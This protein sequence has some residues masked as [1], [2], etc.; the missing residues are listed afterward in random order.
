MEKLSKINMSNLPSFVKEVFGIL[1]DT[2]TYLVGG[3][4]R[5]II[6]GKEPKDFDFA[7]NLYPESVVL[8]FESQ[9][10]DTIPTGIDYGTV[11]VMIDKEPIEITTFRKDVKYLDGRRPSVISFSETI[12]ED[13]SRR[14]F[15]I[16]AMAVNSTGEITDPYDGMIDLQKGIVKTVG[17]A[18]DRF[19][20]DKLRMLR[21][22][23]FAS[24]FNFKLDY[25]I[26]S[27]VHMIYDISNLSKERITSE[28]GKIITSETPSKYFMQMEFIYMISSVIPELKELYKLRQ[29]N[30]NHCYTNVYEHSVKAMDKVEPQ[31]H[32]RLAMLFHDLGKLET[33]T[34]DENGIDHF[35]QHDKNSETMTKLIMTRLKY[36]NDMINKVTTLIGNHMLRYDE[37]KP[38]TAR[39]FLNRMGDNWEDMIKI[40]VADRLGAVTRF[41]GLEKIFR[42]KFECERAIKNEDCVSTNQLAI[43]GNDL[44]KMGLPQGK[45][46]GII[47]N[48]ATE[49]VL[50]HPEFN[51]VEKLRELVEPQILAYTIL[52]NA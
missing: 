39:R 27:A 23:R 48:M 2:E 41:S 32:L 21:A 51:T 33:K 50:E 49:F 8:L 9:G 13:L 17:R 44:I 29:N 34:T 38:K 40:M 16:N 43:N 14:D 30:P 18:T 12:E 31:E 45:E 25:E 46:I 28:L 47:L 4:V 22:Y 20:E 19:K 24:R 1:H 36:S 5:D 6:L 52:N 3:A 7:T 26:T 15:T 37:V 11:T 42:L 35:Y 10:Y